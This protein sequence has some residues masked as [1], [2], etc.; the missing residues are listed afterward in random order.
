MQDADR[1][2]ALG[3]V[4]IARCFLVGG[5]MGTELYH[6]DDP[7]CENRSPDD[8]SWSIDHFYSKLF[9]LPATMNTKSGKAEAEKRVAYMKA[10]LD[11]LSQEIN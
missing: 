8:K 9:K 6:P 5:S 1:L 10:Y 7:F 11:K 3:A 4:G 2:D